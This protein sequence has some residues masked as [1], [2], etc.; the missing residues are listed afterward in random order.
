MRIATLILLCLPLA[1]LAEE[2]T[3]LPTAD[4]LG[5]EPGG[6]AAS[7]EFKILAGERWAVQAKIERNLRAY[8]EAKNKELEARVA[9]LQNDAQLKR[10]MEQVEARIAEACG[11][12]PK[13]EQPASEFWAVNPET[14]D[15][16]CKEQTQ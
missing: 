15:P 6:V 3:P 8:A 1:L 12:D 2:A 4:E 16:E 5:L 14:G 7:P 11:W 10:E 13:G 9:A